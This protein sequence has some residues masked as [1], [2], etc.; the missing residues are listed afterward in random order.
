MSVEVFLPIICLTAVTDQC[1]F[2]LVIVLL[3]RMSVS[4][5]GIGKRFTTEAAY[6]GDIMLRLAMV[7]QSVFTHEWW[8]AFRAEVANKT[9]AM[10]VLDVL[11][12]FLLCFPTHI[13]LLALVSKASL[14]V[15]EYFRLASKFLS[16]SF[17]R[18]CDCL[19][20]FLT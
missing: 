18:R 15:N 8:L 12:Q 10:G 3:A 4:A 14:S 6:D 19:W 9:F 17:T 2:T 7:R 11:F 13:A 1:H 16:A 5:V 20:A